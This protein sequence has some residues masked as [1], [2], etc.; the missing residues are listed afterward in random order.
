MKIKS[1]AEIELIKKMYPEGTKVVCDFMDDPYDPVPE[2]TCGEVICV[3]SIG[4]LHVRWEN[5]SGL[6][7][8]LDVDRFHIVR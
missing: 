5:G 1:K 2:G 8:N 4:Q 6:A 3:D 7:L